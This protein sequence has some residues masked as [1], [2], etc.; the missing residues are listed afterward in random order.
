MH[1]AW[2]LHSVRELEG[3]SRGRCENT[4]T[5]SLKRG[6]AAVKRHR[7]HFQ[8][9][10]NEVTVREATASERRGP[11]AGRV[12]EVSERG[13]T[14]HQIQAPRAHHDTCLKA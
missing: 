1:C 7:P 9:L 8:L 3:A 14:A 2:F 5:P 4:E 10:H 11:E 12:L 13:R 6:A